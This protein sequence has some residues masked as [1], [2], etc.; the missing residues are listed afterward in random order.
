VQQPRTS[1]LSGSVL[2]NQ[3]KNPAQC[4]SAALL[5]YPKFSDGMA[6][7][8]ASLFLGLVC[9]ASACWPP[10]PAA[11]PTTQDGEPHPVSA[12]RLP[13]FSVGVSLCP[14]RDAL[15]LVP[16][17]AWPRHG[18]TPCR[19]R[20]DRPAVQPAA[21]GHKDHNDLYA[22]PEPRPLPTFISVTNTDGRIRLSNP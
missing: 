8:T 7:V 11:P 2:S 20:P 5:F 19:S 14:H 10:W 1:T 15:S 16:P 3:I 17:P 22:R 18:P 9:H 6:S 13:R 21:G 12:R 4:S